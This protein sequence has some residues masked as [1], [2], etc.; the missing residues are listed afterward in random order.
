MGG[1]ELVEKT[2]TKAHRE[3]KDEVHIIAFAKEK[4]EFRGEF[5]EDV[6]NINEDLFFKSAPFNFQLIFQL[7]TIVKTLKIHRIYVHLPNPYMH[8][9]VRYAKMFLKDSGVV[10]VAVYHSDIVNQK[11]LGKIYNAYFKL[12]ASTYDLWMCSSEK[13]WNS[14]QI[15]NK[16]KKEQQRIIPF[17]TDG[18]INY[19]AR[20]VFK[21][22]CLAVG[23]LV[24]YK[25][26][27]FLLDALRDTEF[28]LHIIGNGPELE[29][30][31]EKAS[32]NIFL[33]RHLSDERKSELFNE[34]DV[35]IVSSINRSEAYG[36]TIVEAFEAGM[37]VVASN[38]NSGVT[39]L[40]QHEK[41]GLVFDI[42][43]KEQLLHCLNR[44]KN[45][46]G[47]FESLSHNARVFFEEAL[48]FETFK[49][50]IK[51]I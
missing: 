6:I 24:P 31:K 9:V 16:L 35:L 40:A 13:L 41:T 37:P 5:G 25:G 2:I 38:I 8:E 36:M 21:G 4:K 14:S 48:T 27:D 45:E 29:K 18:V 30:L 42:K 20:K 47:L 32:K 11:F 44:L 39:Y 49:E 34:C 51:N 15:L 10:V 3:L 28:E 7:K 1:I 19:R 26:F 33:H 46:V 12:T 22:K 50:K 23:R 17:C 43:N